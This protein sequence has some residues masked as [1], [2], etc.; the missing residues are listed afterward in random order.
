M[1]PASQRCFIYSCIYL[2]ILIIS[3]LATFLGT[4]SLSVL[5]CRNAVIQLSRLWSCLDG[6][7]EGEGNFEMFNIN[8]LL[9]VFVFN[10]VCCRPTELDALIFGHLFTALTTALPSDRLAEAVRNYANLTDFCRRIHD[11]YFSDSQ[12]DVC[13][14]WLCKCFYWVLEG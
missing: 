5:M 14:D 1:R 11:T 13:G 3:Y 12:N 2:R 4:N 6:E 7:L 8:L 10:V 9:L